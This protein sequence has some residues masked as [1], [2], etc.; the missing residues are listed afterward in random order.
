ML[1]SRVLTYPAGLDLTYRGVTA[2][3]RHKNL[4]FWEWLFTSFG[5]VGSPY[6]VEAQVGPQRFIFTAEPENIKAILATQFEDYGK[7]QPFHEDWKDFLGDSIFTTDGEQW[8][9]SRSLIRPQFI[10]DRVSDLA[11]FEKH[12][13]VLL[14][15]MGGKG[16]E[17]D[18]SA[19]FFRCAFSRDY[20]VGPT[21]I[22]CLDQIHIG[23][24][25][26]LPTRNERRQPPQFSSRVRRGLCRSATGAKHHRPSRVS[27]PAV[28]RTRN[29][30]SH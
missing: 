22:Q 1:R 3:I 20:Q 16:Q 29:C 5:T 30:P 19:L 10:K 26:R 24:S 6:T 28:L 11:I 14:G 7:G 4:E 17:I 8:H 23:R 27:R 12:V 9:D 2:A 18:V 15:L 25:N 13:N 21:L